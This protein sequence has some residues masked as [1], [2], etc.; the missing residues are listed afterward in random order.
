MTGGTLGFAHFGN[1]CSS[2]GAVATV[3]TTLFGDLMN[4]MFEG[5]PRYLRKIINSD[6]G[7]SLFL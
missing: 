3:K 2:N 1:K 7:D 4:V 5:C 6:F